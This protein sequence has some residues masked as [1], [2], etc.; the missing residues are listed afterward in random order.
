MPI[1]AIALLMAAAGNSGSFSPEDLS[2]LLGWWDASDAGSI[3]SS[4]GAVSQWNDKSGQG[5]H[6]AQ[7]NA[8]EK[9]T[10]GS[11]TQNGLNVLSFDGGDWIGWNPAAGPFL[12]TFQTV[13]VVYYDTGDN[14]TVIGEGRSG[15]DNG[16]WTLGNLITSKN[17]RGYHESAAGVTRW[18]L[19]T[20]SPT[21][22]PLRLTYRRTPDTGT[23]DVNLDDS[24]GGS[25]SIT[26][27][28]LAN[29]GPHNRVTFGA[30]RRTGVGGHIT[31]WIGEIIAYGD[32]KTGADLAALE[33]YLDTKW[34]V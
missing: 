9:P 34:G 11:T 14:N 21:T 29:S 2:G 18:D 27:A 12:N 15:N 3:T 16:M 33:N 8:S 5:N 31:G 23:V 1:P 30:L 19:N 7:A 32:R 26:G 13:V 20:G 22:S 24:N 6:A 4:S 10:T 17:A 25:A 28:S